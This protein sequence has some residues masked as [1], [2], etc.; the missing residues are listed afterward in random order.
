MDIYYNNRTLFVNLENDITLD[1]INIL[2]SRIFFILDHYDIKDVNIKINKKNYN[3]YLFDSL[4]SNYN[5]KYKGKL[6]IE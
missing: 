6:N 1:N 3:E 2:Q 5:K 4:I